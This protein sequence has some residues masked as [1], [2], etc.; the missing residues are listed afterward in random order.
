MGVNIK[1]GGGVNFQ[2]SGGEFQGKGGEFP[3]G[4][5]FPRQWGVNFKAL[6]IFVFRSRQNPR[7]CSM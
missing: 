3:T 4:G 1:A 5:E 2:C 6:I 7:D